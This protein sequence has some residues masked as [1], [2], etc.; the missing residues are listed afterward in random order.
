MVIH[1]LR[2]QVPAF[3]VGE[4]QPVGIVPLRTSPELLVNRDGAPLHVHAVPSEAQQLR[5]AHTRE[6]RCG[7]NV[8]QLSPLCGGQQ[9]GVYSFPLRVYVRLL[10]L[11]APFAAL[12][13]MMCSPG[14]RI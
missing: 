10:I 3:G 14:N 12:F 5:Y 1:I 2:E 4:H 8:F 11:P 13:A 9:G 7:N 6:Q